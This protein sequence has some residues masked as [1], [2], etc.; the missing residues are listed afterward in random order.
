MQF[1]TL[2]KLGAEALGTALP[3]AIVVGSGIMGAA[4]TTGMTRS[5]HGCLPP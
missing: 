2:Q 5:P 1:S 3:L 4:L